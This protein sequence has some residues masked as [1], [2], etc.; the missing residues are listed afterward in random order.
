MFKQLRARL[1]RRCHREVK[2]HVS[3]GDSFGYLMSSLTRRK[4]STESFVLT[5]KKVSLGVMA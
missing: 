4:Q 2:V 5:L 1:F 3:K